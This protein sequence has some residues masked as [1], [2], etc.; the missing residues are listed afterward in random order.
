MHIYVDEFRRFHTTIFTATILFRIGTLGCGYQGSGL[1]CCPQVSEGTTVTS[2]AS[3]VDGQKCGVSSVQ[4]KDYH[5]VGAY[6][7]VA[8]V[9]F[10]SK[11]HK[12]TKREC[13]LG[14]NTIESV[15]LHVY[16]VIHF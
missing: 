6:P 16:R 5:G 12:T 15:M 11:F 3:Q 14:G 9:G 13:G 8:R 2:A 7:W 4:G 1:V 10:K